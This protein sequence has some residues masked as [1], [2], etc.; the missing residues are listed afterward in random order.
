MSGTAV[1][2]TSDGSPS[3]PVHHQPDFGGTRMRDPRLL[4]AL[5]NLATALVVMADHHWLF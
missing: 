3:A 1:S 5:I 4:I 2:I